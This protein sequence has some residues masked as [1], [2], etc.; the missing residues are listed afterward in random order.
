MLAAVLKSPGC[1]ELEDVPDPEC[2]PGGALLE[3]LACAVCGTDI[4]MRQAGHKDLAYPRILGHEIVGRIAVIDGG[5]GL[6]IGDIVQVWPGI[7]CG[8]CRPC[9]RDEDNRCREMKILGFSRDGGF[10]ELLALP[11][12]CIS[13]GVN[14]LPKGTDPALAALAEP[15]A[16]CINGQEMAGVSKGDTVL[17]IGAGPI[18][19]LHALLADHAGA[20]KIMAMEMLPGRILEMK[21]HTNADVIS[22]D[23]ACESS[24]SLEKAVLDGTNGAG[25]D[26]IMMATP[27]FKVSSRLCRLLAPGGRI[28]VFSGP[29]LGNYIEPMDQRMLHYRELTITGAYGCSSRQNRKAVELLCSGK[30]RA[31]WIITKRARL[32]KIEDAL[33]HS[34]SR[35]GMKSVVCGKQF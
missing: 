5:C 10:A 20:E 1:L 14:L 25:A 16:C 4:K 34:A 12:Q 33:S 19:G 7:A 13:R 15:L 6:E 9:R 32:A 24:E 30:I 2:P 27:E 3:V 21:R 22:A 23:G 8:K 17:I 11:G 18:G 28:C 26:V 29:R 31:D 35:S